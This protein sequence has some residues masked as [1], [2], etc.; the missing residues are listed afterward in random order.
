MGRTEAGD[1]TGRSPDVGAD[2]M[3]E[4]QAA[5]VEASQFR[6]LLPL[7]LT[8]AREADLGWLALLS[9]DCETR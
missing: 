1:S 6:L 7:T 4:L 2:I 9:S 8:G 5:A 3:R